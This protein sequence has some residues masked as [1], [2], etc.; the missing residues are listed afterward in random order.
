[1]VNSQNKRC[2]WRLA[3]VGVGLLHLSPVLAQD[4]SESQAAPVEEST[5]EIQA[6]WRYFVPVPIPPPTN[7]AASVPATPVNDRTAEPGTRERIGPP[8]VDL[9][10]EPSIFSRARPDLADL[11]LYAAS[12]QTVPYAL[13]YLR[14]RPARE[15]V[16]ADEF[17]RTEPK[18]GP[19]EL[20][21]DLHRDDVQHN[22][23]QIITL[24]Q[25]FRR[26]AEI[27][28]SDDGKDWR[29]LVAANLIRFSHGDQKVDVDSLTYADTRVRYLRVRVYPDPNP[30]LPGG[31]PDELNISSV[32]VL[33]QVHVP[34]EQLRMPGTVNPREPVRTYG[35]PG[36]AWIIDLGGDNIPCD[37]I[38]VDVADSEFARDIV[39]EAE[40]PSG[41]LAQAR[42]SPVEL[43]S[44]ALWQRK[45][46]DPKRPLIA[47]FTEVQTRRLR[48]QVTDHR[49]PPLTIRS[50][51]FSAAARQVVFARPALE[52]GELRLFFGNPQGES[53]HYDFARNLA[54]ELEPAPVRT[55]LQK[56]EENPDFV[57]PPQPFTERFPWLIYVV[58]GAVTAVLAAVILSLSRTAITLHD[59]G[60]ET[61]ADLRKTFE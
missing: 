25:D 2:G 45:P 8:L 23:I 3:L 11:R 47:H 13:R 41:P 7:D 21:L 48:L 26:A 30:G 44:D 51:V 60:L 37:Q 36:S 14:P 17:N 52:V 29:Q 59:A 19:H 24:G 38:E 39:V 15:P 46:G 40:F 9:I 20:T 53:P 18:E 57:P 6:R 35:A 10:L 5:T 56:V 33:R 49:N 42:F 61:Q 55:V 28:G 27:E 31:R 16:P 34:G 4:A 22:E 58:L 43:I 32:H 1:M 12:G 50:V 54:E